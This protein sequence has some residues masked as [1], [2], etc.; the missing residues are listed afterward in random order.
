[1]RNLSFNG[2]KGVKKYFIAVIITVICAIIS[3]IVLYKFAQIGLYFK[4]FANDYVY[5]VF[6]F[7]NGSL[8][9]PHLLSCLFYIYLCFAISY[10][11][12]LK[13]LTLIIIYIRVLFITLYST[14]L[15]CMASVGG[16]TVAV[17]V[18][19]PSSIISV[20]ACCVVSQFCDII[21]KKFVFAV[22]AVLAVAD[23]IILVI[24]VNVVFRVIIV[25]V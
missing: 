20:L 4:N 16:I 21:N 25:I 18:F 2:C 10:F 11:T 23:T 13:Y 8:I 5:F 15:I 6:N 17:I 3:G 14:I 9:F 1:M 12:K 19:I 7:K 22:P 24:L